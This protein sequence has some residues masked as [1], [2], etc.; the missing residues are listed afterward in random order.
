[1]TYLGSTSTP[2]RKQTHQL[3]I[4]IKD[5]REGVRIVNTTAL[6]KYY[7]LL[8]INTHLLPK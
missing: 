8:Y 3:Q 1:M 4:N 6:N 7:S 5:G 2:D